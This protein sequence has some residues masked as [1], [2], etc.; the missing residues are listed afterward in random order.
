M[1]FIDYFHKNKVVTHFL[2]LLLIFGGL[3]SYKKLGKLEDPAFTIR[4]AMVVTLY[5]GADAHRV[6]LQVTDKVEESIQKIPNLEYVESVSRDGYSQVKVKLN[7]N[8]P[9]DQINQYWD[10]IRKKL[11][12]AKL[13]LPIGTIPPIV[14]DDYGAVYGMFL[15]IKSDGFTYKELDRYAKYIKKELNSIDGVSKSELYGIQEEVL[16]LDID[17]EK[18]ATMN[19]NPKMIATVLMR[20]NLVS[21]GA[22]ENFGSKQLNLNLNSQVNTIDKLKNMIILSRKLPNG[23]NQ[24]IRISNIAKVSTGYKKPYTT[25]M[26]LDNQRT[27]GLSLAPEVGTN[28]LVTGLKIDNKIKEIEEKLPRGINIEKIYYQP[29]LVKDAINNFIFNLIMSIG[30]VI[31]VLLI[32]MGLRSGLVIGSGLVFSILGTLIFM[33]PMG[34]DLQR[35]SLGSFIIAMGMLV[36]NSIVI[37]D[38][39]LVARQNGEAPDE[40]LLRISHK[41][42][43]PL[44]GG[45]LIASIAFLPGSLMPTY[46]GEYTKSSFWV[47]SVSLILSWLL[48]VTQIPVYCRKFL[49]NIKIKEPGKIEVT[50]YKKSR[51]LLNTLMNHQKASI[52]AVF[53]AF[54]ISMVAFIGIPKSFFPDS[55]KKMFRINI[56]TSEGT[57]IQETEKIIKRIN[58]YLDTKKEVTSITMAI[59]ASPSRYYVAT[60]PQVPNPSFGQLIVKVKELKD[61]NQVDMETRRFVNSNL[62]GVFIATKK[63]PNGVA[64]EYPIEAEFSGPDPAVLR[65]LSV[66]AMKIMKTSPNVFNVKT[67]WREKVLTWDGDFDQVVGRKLGISPLD[68]IFSLNSNSNGMPIGFIEKDDK[69]IPIIL[70]S[71]DDENNLKNIS[72]IPVWGID[73]RS[74]PLSAIMKNQKLVFKDKNIWRRNRSRSIKVQCDLSTTANAGEVLKEF[75]RQ[76]EEIKLPKGYSL[77]WRGEYFENVKNTNALIS[78]VPLV[79]IIMFTICLLLFAN[80]TSPILIFAM[81]PLAMIGIVPGLLITGKSFGFMSIIGVIALAGIMIKNIIVLMDEINIRMQIDNS[82]PRSVVIE[83]SISRIR[84]VSLAAGTTVFGMVPL[85]IDPLYGD[86][87]ATI[88]FGLIASTILTLFIFPVIYSFIKRIK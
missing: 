35:V 10:I 58:D 43:L 29:D 80:L 41:N 27:I 54:I 14:L 8:T 61:I 7:E 23:E 18:L 22:I 79:S 6:E 84:A 11:V 69:K 66:E 30:T 39:F 73:N 53:A 44:L 15:G 70:K 21:A 71:I 88:I 65:R 86:M 46:V 52:L 81:L 87:A 42:T 40:S 17:K 28:V 16:Y 20:Q 60:I 57:K 62:P 2:V 1:K 32:A 83:S 36:D 78:S 13:N 63:Y 82:N 72:Q 56:W 5:P 68:I 51:K 74:H 38:G 59:G 37:V 24:V 19:L 85:L 12:D 75:K 9:N 33:A 50:I 48:A 55:D 49:S 34:I 64:V 4:E 26:Y 76:I 31:A 3:F 67:N 47:I 45:T 25:K 77:N